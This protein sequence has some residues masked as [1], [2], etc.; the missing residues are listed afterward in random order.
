MFQ[1]LQC[2]VLVSMVSVYTKEMRSCLCNGG[3]VED[4]PKTDVFKMIMKEVGSDTRL[5]Y[6]LALNERLKTALYKIIHQI[7]DGDFAGGCAGKKQTVLRSLLR[8]SR[9]LDTAV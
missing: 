5:L 9:L 6:H 7:R 2:V 4:F 1:E 3:K 8:F